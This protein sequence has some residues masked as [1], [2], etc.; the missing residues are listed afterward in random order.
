MGLRKTFL[1]TE[2]DNAFLCKIPREDLSASFYPQGGWVFAKDV[3]KI[4][5]LI[6][7]FLRR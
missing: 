7:K 1:K 2:L 6:S 5:F 4:C 3:P